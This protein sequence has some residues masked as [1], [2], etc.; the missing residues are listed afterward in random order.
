MDLKRSTDAEDYNHSSLAPLEDLDLDDNNED[1]SESKRQ[2]RMQRNRESAAISRE[3]KRAHIEQLEIRLSEL[4][5]IV[6]TL[7]TE[8]DALR[9]GHLPSVGSAPMQ[10]PTAL[11]PA[12][13]EL[14]ESLL[15]MPC[16]HS[17]DNDSES[18]DG[19]DTLEFY[20]SLEV[21]KLFS[22]DLPSSLTLSAESPV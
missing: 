3:R 15:L 8:N 14:E 18:N 20:S 6:A 7:R 16:L 12:P 13:A 9:S 19:T 22:K 17:S 4:S 2:K 10:V 11:V 21:F 5:Q 1:P